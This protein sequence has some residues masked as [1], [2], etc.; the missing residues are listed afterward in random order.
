MAVMA[1]KTGGTRVNVPDGLHPAICIGVYDVGT[2]LSAKWGN[3]SK[4]VLIVW[5]LPEQKMNDGRPLTISRQYTCSLH[6]KAGLRAD[7]EKWR[8]KPFSEEEVVGFD[9]IKLLGKSCQ[10]QVMNKRVD[11]ETYSNVAG[12]MMAN[13]KKFTPTNPLRSYSQEDNGR[14]IPDGTPEWIVKKIKASQEWTQAP[15]GHDDAT[16][17]YHTDDEA[18]DDGIPF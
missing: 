11:G 8:N 17:G 4:Q 6:A 2:H 16:D 5:E 10:L 1:K 9:L 3:W 7:L 15:V 14:T 13:G 18:G 12:I